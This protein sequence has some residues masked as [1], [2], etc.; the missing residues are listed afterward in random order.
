MSLTPGYSAFFRPNHFG[1][2]ICLATTQK[3]N[4]MQIVGN[5]HAL[6]METF[7]SFLLVLTRQIRQ[8]VKPVTSK[9]SRRRYS[10]IWRFSCCRERK[11]MQDMK[12]RARPA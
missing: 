2:L 8:I 9:T 6:S 12:V 11:P 1:I 10:R 5:I 7:C 3:K 4:N